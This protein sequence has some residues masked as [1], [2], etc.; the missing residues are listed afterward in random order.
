MLKEERYD[1]IL[2]L[3]D[4]EM[5]TSAQNLANRLYVSMPTIRRDL[6]ELDSRGLL[7]RS[8]G[9]AKRL[10]SEHILM[11]ANHRKSI[12]PNEKRRICKKAASLITEKSVIFIDASTTALNIAEYLTERSLVTVVTNSV[13]LAL[14][15]S[16]RGIKCYTTGGELQNNS[17]GFAGSYAEEMISKFNFDF[18]FFSSHGINDSGMI[19]DTTSPAENFLRQAVCRL[20][21]KKV[22][23]AVHTKFGQQAQF[24]LMPLDDVDIVITDKEPP[25]KMRDILKGKIIVA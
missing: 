10:N 22:F 9:G 11:P 17:Y 13:K 18:M 8:H 3:L 4:E 15:L 2:E 21:A 20:S 19:V 14:T 5:Y 12:S 23:L 7:I 16:T 24:N 1:K 6:A 25:E